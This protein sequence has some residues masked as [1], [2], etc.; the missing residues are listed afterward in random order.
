M[1][2]TRLVLVPLGLV[3]TGATDAVGFDVFPYPLVE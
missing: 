1:A 3:D 2:A